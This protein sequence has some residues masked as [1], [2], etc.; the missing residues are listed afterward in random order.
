MSLMRA[1]TSASS[2]KSWPPR[3]A[4]DGVWHSRRWQVLSPALAPPSLSSRKTMFL[5]LMQARL[6]LP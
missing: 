4:K 3:E 6:S 1:F 5:L 2:S